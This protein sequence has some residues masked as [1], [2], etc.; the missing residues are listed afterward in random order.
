MW[1]GDPTS[2]SRVVGCRRARD[3]EVTQD[4][5]NPDQTAGSEEPKRPPAMVIASQ[6]WPMWPGDPEWKAELVRTGAVVLDFNA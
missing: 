6:D 3:A 2:T 4:E 5:Q 1:Q